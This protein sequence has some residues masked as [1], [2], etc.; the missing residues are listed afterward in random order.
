MD[1]VIVYESMVGDTRR[2]AEVLAKGM[3]PSA[4]VTVLNVNDA[5]T[6]FPET[7]LVLVGGPT[8]CTA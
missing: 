7:D 4:T 3:A 2:V 6:E 1:A 5:G 8:M